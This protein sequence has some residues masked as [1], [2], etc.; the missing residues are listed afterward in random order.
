MRALILIILISL[1]VQVYA[2]R[3]VLNE[4]VDATLD[5]TSATSTGKD[6]RLTHFANWAKLNTMLEEI[7]QSVEDMGSSLGTAALLDV[8]TSAGNVVQVED[9][10]DG[11]S[12]IN[13]G[14]VVDMPTYS[15][16]GECDEASER[17]FVAFDSVKTLLCK[18]VYGWINLQDGGAVWVNEE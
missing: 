15:N 12:V 16:T 18:G 9:D 14:T 17:N 10:R 13:F 8:G 1:P 5:G 7:Y 2:D 3:V 4:S 6:L 11:N